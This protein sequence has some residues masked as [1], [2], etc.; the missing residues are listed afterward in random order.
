[1]SRLSCP[2]V[3]RVRMPPRRPLDTQAGDMAQAR[4]PAPARQGARKT[5]LT[6]EMTRALNRR[7]AKRGGRTGARKAPGGRIRRA[8]R[9]DA[10]AD[11]LAQISRAGIAPPIREWRFCG[12]LWRFDF[13]WID[14]RIA[15]ELEGGTWS[16]GR[17]TTGKGYAGDVEKYNEAAL[18]GWFVIR[19]TPAQVKDGRAIGWLWR[20]LSTAGPLPGVIRRSRPLAGEGDYTP[21]TCIS[22]NNI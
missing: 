14:Q 1:M 11:F 4:D 12:R 21:A 22:G 8:R 19:F 20:A 13:A 15:G 17:H 7:S 5:Q 6:A 18:L 10:T 2:P 16:G 3:S 9:Y